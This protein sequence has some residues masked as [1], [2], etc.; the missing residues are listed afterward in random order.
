MGPKSRK[1]SH[2]SLD[3]ARPRA[4]PNPN[5]SSSDSSVTLRHPLGY[6]DAS[7]AHRPY[8]RDSIRGHELPQGIFISFLRRTSLGNDSCALAGRGNTMTSPT[9][10]PSRPGAG[11]DSM[12]P[13]FT[14]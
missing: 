12:A 6:S 13:I 2:R 14:T 10:Q 1:L 4:S 11:C 7:G 5:A 3:L 9:F 8:W